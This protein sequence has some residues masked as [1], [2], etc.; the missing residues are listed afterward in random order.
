MKPLKFNLLSKKILLTGLAAAAL[1]GCN[2]EIPGFPT[3]AD[4]TASGDQTAPIASPTDAAS[5]SPGQGS[6]AAAQVIRCETANYYADLAF[7]GGQAQ[8][9]LVRKPSTTSFDKAETT[10]TDNPDGSVTFATARGDTFY[11][12]VYPNATCFLQ[13]VASN[14]AVALEEN[15]SIKR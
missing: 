5:P 7:Q 1:T 3:G 15:G 12:R 13:A 14:G 2:L 10:R 9:T 8:M 6:P 11:A 4:E